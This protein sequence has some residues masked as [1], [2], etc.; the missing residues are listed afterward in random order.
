[1]SWLSGSG[2][3]YPYW[4]GNNPQPLP[5]GSF[6]RNDDQVVTGAN[7]S[8]ALI[9]DTLLASSQT[10]YSGSKVYVQATG[11]YRILYT[12]QVDTT[13]GGQQALAVYVRLNG[14]DVP[15]SCSFF[16]LQNNAENIA[17]SEILLPML[18]GDYIE[19]IMRSSDANMTASYIPAGGVAP[20]TYPASPAIITNIQKIA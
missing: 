6:S 10:Y 14:V 5:Y 7:V 8:T 2:I 9:Y 11:V 15:D 12:I 1:M 20:N 16:T 18:A 19:I 3:G 4:L 13:S 17:A